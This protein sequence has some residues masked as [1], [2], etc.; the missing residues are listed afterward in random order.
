[1]H[2]HVANIRAKLR[3]PSRSAAVALATREGLL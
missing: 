1:V 2:R 3:T